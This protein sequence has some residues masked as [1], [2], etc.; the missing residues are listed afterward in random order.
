MGG[1]SM[2]DISQKYASAE[3][4]LAQAVQAHNDAIGKTPAIVVDVTKQTKALEDAQRRLAEVE[5][6][7]PTKHKATTLELM[8]LQD[9]Q[10]KVTDAQL[11]LTAA[12]QAGSAGTVS[13]A[14]NLEKYQGQIDDFIKTNRRYISDQSEV[15]AGYATLTRSGL[16][17]TEVQRAMNDAVDL[18][19]IKHISLS[20]AVT[21]LDNAEHGRMRGLIDL[22]ITTA[23]YTDANGNLIP[24]MRSAA[25]AM[26]ELD[27]KLKGGRE[28]LTTLQQD[29]NTL[30]NDWQNLAQKGGPALTTELDLVVTGITKV[31]DEFDKIGKDNKLWSQI[32]DRLVDMG[33]WIHDDVLKPWAEATGSMDPKTQATMRNYLNQQSARASGGPVLPGGIY[34]V[35]E[36]RAETLVMFPGGGGQVIPDGGAGASAGASAGSTYNITVPVTNPQ[37]SAWEIASEL[38]WAM[39]TRRV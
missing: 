10:K 18:A 16:S 6:G 4:G 11:A 25:Q 34:T 20:D 15:V 39:K 1:K 2:I 13:A 29:S 27:T 35:G 36:K 17:Q 12:E 22:G 30:S 37:S 7:M 21:L 23:K 33:R 38:K 26:G 8:H 28:T 24:T 14:I 9:A 5:A 31:Y 32:S 19:A 3:L